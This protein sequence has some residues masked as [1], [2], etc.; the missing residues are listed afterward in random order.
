MTEKQS[1]ATIRPIAPGDL[2]GVI[3]IDRVATGQSR[4]GFYEKRLSA[5]AREP[6]A[7]VS[8]G[9]VV[10]GR[11]VGSAFAYILDGEFGGVAPVAVLDSVNV[12]PDA[13]GRGVGRQLIGALE[14][15]LRG[16]GVRELQTQADWTQHEMVQFF[17]AAGFQLAPRLVVERSTA[18]ATDF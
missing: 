5:A 12:H 17:G 1:T 2:E 3:E 10:D 15:A 14:T 11:L 16:R 18:E 4:R 13:Q 9:A 8:L 6:G 7:F